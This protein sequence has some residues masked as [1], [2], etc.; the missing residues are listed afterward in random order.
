MA[1]FLMFGKY[2][3][4]ALQDMSAARTQHAVEAIKKHGGEVQAMYATL[5]AHDLVLVVSLPGAAEAMKVS[6]A[7]GRMTGIGFTTAPAV[8]VEEFDKLLAG[9]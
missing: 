5:G 8:T 4:Q 1:T 7:L 6:V 3:A 9:R 2:S